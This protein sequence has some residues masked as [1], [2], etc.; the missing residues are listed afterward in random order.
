MTSD[1]PPLSSLNPVVTGP[2]APSPP[3]WK[4]WQA[5]PPDL[6]LTRATVWLV[7]ATFLLA[8]MAFMQVIILSTTDSSTRK[9]A[10]AAMTSATIAQTALQT[11][12]D[13]FRAEQRP[14]IWLTNDL[15]S[16]QYFNLANKTDG[17]Q[18]AWE[19]HFTNYGR[20]PARHLTFHHLI[21]IG[22]KVEEGYGYN[23]Q[24][25][26]G[27]PVPTNKDD[28]AAV[29][30]KP[31]ISAEQ[32]TKL[33]ATDEAIGISGEISYEDAYGEKYTTMFCLRHLAL[34]GILYCKEG[35]DIK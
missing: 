30:S 17:G 12:R 18:I 2:P 20:S 25:S 10:N 7:I 3:W 11:A 14:I 32:F 15:G 6:A 27:A 22:D 23:G 26:V 31:E 9:A 21:K 28:R 5:P 29:A 24:P 34:G 4:F 13:N 35:N 1:E 16:P 19:W 33:M 8:A